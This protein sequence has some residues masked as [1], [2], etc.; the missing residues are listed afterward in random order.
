MTV[1]AVS[2]QRREWICLADTKELVEFVEEDLVLAT[3]IL[4]GQEYIGVTADSVPPRIVS[5]RG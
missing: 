5:P 1:D 3:T 2:P 4:H